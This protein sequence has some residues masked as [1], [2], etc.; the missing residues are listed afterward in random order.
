MFLKHASLLK[1]PNLLSTKNGI[2]TR[3]FTKKSNTMS[4][5][6]PRPHDTANNLQFTT[7]GKSTRTKI[8]P[9]AVF[10]RSQIR[11]NFLQEKFFSFFPLFRAK[12]EKL[13]KLL[14]NFLKPK[15]IILFCSFHLLLL[16]FEFNL[17]KKWQLR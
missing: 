1:L 8:A 3:A 9:L 6:S 7:F 11:A 14:L 17:I 13:P 12:V 4:L 2:G 10:K 5:E 16:S 15:Q